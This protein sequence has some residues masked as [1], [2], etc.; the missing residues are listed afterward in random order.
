MKY[1]GAGALR[2]RVCAVHVRQGQS[3]S[4]QPGL[5]IGVHLGCT[6]TAT[7]A[8]GSARCAA[9]ARRNAATTAGS[10]ALAAKIKLMR[11]F[12]LAWALAIAVIIIMLPSAAGV[13]L[14][15]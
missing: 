7:T 4:G 12:V 8:A 5:A 13:P 1:L 14:F 6:G 3:D 10:C 11:R 9:A 2:R 15:G